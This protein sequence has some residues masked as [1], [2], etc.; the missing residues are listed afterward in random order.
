[1]CCTFFSWIF[2]KNWCF[3][4]GVCS[5]YLS[6]WVCRFPKF[7]QAFV[8][9]S[10][11]DYLQKSTEF[12]MWGE[13]LNMNGF[14]INLA[15]LIIVLHGNQ[16]DGDWKLCWISQFSPKRWYFFNIFRWLRRMTSL[17]WFTELEDFVSDW[18]DFQTTCSLQQ[19]T[20]ACAWVVYVFL[21]VPN[22]YSYIKNLIEPWKMFSISLIL[23]GLFQEFAL[24]DNNR[25][26]VWHIW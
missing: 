20:L 14:Y 6:M 8:F 26:D 16:I 15:V 7:S 12:C 9:V 19:R 5:A 10:R 4:C 13:R 11:S 24:Q 2:L 22:F 3:A 23:S 1:M 25:R 21:V 17:S 18:Q